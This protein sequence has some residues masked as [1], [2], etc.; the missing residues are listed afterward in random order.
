MTNALPDRSARE[1][2]LDPAQSFIV[3]AP[4]GSG[5]TE[6]LIQRYLQLLA[7]V[8]APEEIVAA[9]FTL[10][11]AGEMRQRVIDALRLA[12]AGTPPAAEHGRIAFNLAKQVLADPGRRAWQLE[13][14]PAR[15]RI[16]TL[17]SLNNW[18]AGLAPLTDGRSALREVSDAPDELY[19]TA[20]RATLGL[21]VADAEYSRPVAALLAHLD[22]DAPRFEQLVVQMLRKR[23]QWLTRLRESPDDRAA[24]EAVLGAFIDARIC[25]ADS[26]LPPCLRDEI[27]DL[28]RHAA[29]E[30]G[31]ERPENRLAAWLGTTAWPSTAGERMACWP[32]LAWVLL[33][34]DGEW[35][36]SINKNQGFGTSGKAEKARIEVVICSCRDAPGFLDALREVQ[37]LPPPVYT[38]SQWS[39]LVA[40]SQTLKLATAELELLFTDSAVADF[41]AVAAAALAV[42]GPVDEPS[43]LALALDYRLRHLLVDEF[44]DTSAVQFQLLERLTAGWEPEDGRT[45]FLVGDP[46]QSIYRFREADVR[47]FERVR[48]RGLGQIQP[49]FLQLQAN[50]RSRPD[51]V[52]WTN[53]T[54]GRVF[55]AQADVALGAVRHARSV[56]M[57]ESHPQGTSARWHWLPPGDE[58]AESRA[59]IAIVTETQRAHPEQSICILVRSRRQAAP[60]L[61]AL[62]VARIAFVAPEIAELARLPVAQDLLALTRALQHPAD[63][64]AWLG[65]LRSPTVGLTL[66][67]IA[68]IAA[69]DHVTP[70]P[71][72]LA[73]TVEAGGLSAD[74]ESRARRL[75][76]VLDRGKS[77]RGRRPLREFVEGVWLALGG[78]ESLTE[79]SEREV[80]AIVLDLLEP[81]DHGGDCPDVLAFGEEIA[82]GHASAG[83]G[84][85]GLQIMTMHKAKGLEFDTV[86]LPSLDRG[87]SS[88]KTPVLLWQDLE[89]PSGASA[90]VLAPCPASDQDQDPHFAWLAALDR[91]RQDHE[92][93]R[94]MYVAAT[95]AR[96]RLHLLARLASADDDASATREPATPRRG[97]LLGYLWPAVA[98]EAATAFAN[99]PIEQEPDRKTPAWILPRLRRLPAGWVA[100]ELPAGLLVSGHDESTRADLPEY[101]WAGAEARHVGTIVH[102]W[103]QWVAESGGSLASLDDHRIETSVARQVA[104]FGYSGQVASGVAARVLRNLRGLRTDPQ[105]AWIFSRE[106][107]EAQC[108]LALT[109]WEGGAFRELKVDRTF[110]TTAGERWI[111]D[112]KTTRHEGG[113][114]EAFLDAEVERHRPQ[115]RRY[116]EAFRGLE[117]RPTRLALYFPELGMLRE[118]AAE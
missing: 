116:R 115:L 61:A 18:L 110:V 77:V 72:L 94:L 45:L 103:L 90:L 111:V 25:A 67:D 66:N 118:I 73:V 95:R 8:D 69:D 7:C 57:R 5:K 56:A 43:D 99:L 23:D 44:Q 52:D 70:I 100:A 109:V 6:L 59:V 36:K 58:G 55:P 62:R 4:A 75:L 88:G 30:L 46:M 64:L 68:T 17:D 51:L 22:N 20:A 65:V 1:R 84:R 114:L 16:R 39:A 29:R 40:M 112:Y 15:M 107:R 82:R 41:P 71:Q 54:F 87:A 89:M 78:V 104:A 86:I 13:R 11:A 108:E 21:L 53:A 48:V 38:E 79:P 102:R 98:T 34:N 3:Q 60:I 9:T 12:A 113:A 2:A 19:R 96:E 32:G 27:L 63:R 24:T 47:L 33:T 81:L 76:A 80:A 37:A 93:M 97:T 85:P 31:P 92:N 105:A 83:S 49:V 50:F 101:D 106:H 35:R 91:E 26:L 14:H 74:G 28:L 10:K 117:A 42:L